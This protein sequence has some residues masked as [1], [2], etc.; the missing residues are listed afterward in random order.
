MNYSVVGITERFTERGTLGIAL[1]P[2]EGLEKVWDT[3]GGCGG[4]ALGGLT[5]GDKGGALVIEGV[6]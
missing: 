3:W 5:A 6:A 2:I 4:S 1:R